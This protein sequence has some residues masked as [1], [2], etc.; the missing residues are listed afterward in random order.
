MVNKFPNKNT[1]RKS[2]FIFSTMFFI[3][4]GLI[5]YFLKDT[6]K[7]SVV[8]V[9]ILIL[10]L[11]IINPFLL[12]RP[13]VFWIKLGDILSKFNSKLVLGIFFY[14]LITPAALIRHLLKSSM[15]VRK[16]SNSFYLKIWYKSRFFCN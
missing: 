13:Y 9:A 7:E 8:L 4:F 6:L 2:G 3:M 15:R 11:S 10:V 12:R 14:I 16:K 1:L 5:P